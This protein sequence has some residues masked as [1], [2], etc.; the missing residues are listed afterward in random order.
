[1]GKRVILSDIAVHRE[2]APSG[3]A[4]FPPDDAEALAAHMQDAYAARDEAAHAGLAAEARARLHERRHEFA[5]RFEEIVLEC[6][7]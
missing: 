1:L 6:A 4:Y 2:Q 3:G 7:G 5:R